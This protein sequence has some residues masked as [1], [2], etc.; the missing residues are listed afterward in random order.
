MIE[1]YKFRDL[2]FNPDRQRHK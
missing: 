2:F 1:S